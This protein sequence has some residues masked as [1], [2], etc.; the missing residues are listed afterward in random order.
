MFEARLVQ[1]NLLKKVVDAVKDLVTDANF[2]CSS[3]GF[4]LQAMDNSHVSLVSLSLRSDGFEHFRCDRNMSMGMSLGNLAKILK[5]AGNDDIV[6]MKAADDGDTVTFMFESPKEDRVSDFELKL[7]DIDSE[8]LGI[9]DTDYAATVTLPAAEYQRI[10]RDLSSI[11]DTVVISA[12]KDGVK[13]SSSGDVGTANIT[14]RQNTTADKKEEQVSID[15]KEPVALTFALRYLNSFAKAT[16]LASHVSLS[17]ARD[18]PVMV[19]Y[20][21][22]DMGHLRFYLAPKIEDED[23]GDMEG[24]DEA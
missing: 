8:H 11:G 19:D 10:C 7:M 2:D 22:S 4:T 14:V 16:P 21:I 9:P 18:L 15:L 1:G 3:S 6:T 13:F 12:T 20:Q 23:G 24:Q 17:M 5:C